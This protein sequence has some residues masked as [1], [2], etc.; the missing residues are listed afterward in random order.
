MARETCLCCFPLECGIKFLAFLTILCFVGGVIDVI[1]FED[2]RWGLF[3]P[4]IACSAVQ[5]ILWMFA[6]GNPTQQT[7]YY[8]FLGYAF[9]MVLTAYSYY[10]VILFNGTLM[11][12]LCHEETVDTINEKGLHEDLT[13]EECRFGGKKIVM[14]DFFVSL[15]LNIYITIVLY[16]WSNKDDN[17][18]KRAW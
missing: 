9:L 15:L 5:S 4:F 6:L 17:S 10:A 12:Y 18:Y 11:D 2:N 3:W 14:I 7:K 1:W 13:V 16:G 8:A